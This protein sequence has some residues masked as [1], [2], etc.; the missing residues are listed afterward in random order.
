MKSLRIGEEVLGRDGRRLGQ[1]ER[2]VVDEQAH[3]AT[4]LVVG[5]RVVGIQHFR[6]AAGE[7]LTADLDAE[8]LRRHPEALPQVVGAAGEHWQAPGGYA[9]GDFLR[10]ASALIGQ[11]PYVPPVH[12]DLDLSAV[13]QIV[14]GSPVFSGR[15]H[16]GNASQVLTDDAGRVTALVLRRPGLLGLRHVLPASHVVEVIGSSVHV[17]LAEA[18]IEALPDYEEADRPA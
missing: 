18:E 17:D 8:R 1:I 5:D 14:P 11:G 16:V 3:Q 7:R 13:H 6:D 9:I 15:Q 2:I 4:H 12:A 10:I